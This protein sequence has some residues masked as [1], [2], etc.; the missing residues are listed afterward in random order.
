MAVAPA[1]GERALVQ[2]KWG[3]VLLL[4]V[5]FAGGEGSPIEVERGFALSV[6]VVRKAGA[7]PFFLGGDASGDL[8]LINRMA[9]GGSV[10]SMLLLAD[11]FGPVEKIMQ[12]L[13]ESFPK[14]SKA[15]GITAA[16]R[17]GS[18]ATT[19]FMP[20]MSICSRGN[21]ARLLSQ[22]ISGLM[23][24]EMDVH[25]VVC[26][27]CLGVGPKVR[28]SSVSG[29]VAIGIGGRPAKEALG[30][31]FGAVNEESLGPRCRRV[32]WWASEVRV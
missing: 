20:S 5:D 30:L 23:L 25:T 13:D 10:R 9:Q 26:Q 1:L 6:A 4:Q 19:S 14:V 18:G 15:G 2:A 29:P 3:K 32:C 31:I 7:V 12:S 11:P 28:I 27:G 21:K 16:L 8:E 17:V 22:G 24:T